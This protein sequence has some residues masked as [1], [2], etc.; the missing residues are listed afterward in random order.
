MPFDDEEVTPI[1]ESESKRDSYNSESKA[2][3]SI[4]SKRILKND[5]ILQEKDLVTVL[6]FCLILDFILVLSIIILIALLLAAAKFLNVE[7]E[8]PIK[9]LINLSSIVCILLYLLLA[10]ISIISLITKIKDQKK[11]YK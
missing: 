11:K 1:E 5:Y 6:F 2:W 3:M 9:I 10:A 4:I 7:S 8:I